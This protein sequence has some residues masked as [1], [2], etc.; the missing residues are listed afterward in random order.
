MRKFAL[1]AIPFSDNKYIFNFGERTY[2]LQNVMRRGVREKE[3]IL[4]IEME[5]RLDG[6]YIHSSQQAYKKEKE[7]CTVVGHFSIKSAKCGAPHVSHI[8]LY[9]QVQYVAYITQC[10][11]VL[12][13]V[14]LIVCGVI[15][16]KYTR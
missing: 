15:V 4:K 11:V 2:F 13:A 10:S 1:R 6:F 5:M 12:S 16:R 14:R 9:V 3:I 7:I 8:Y